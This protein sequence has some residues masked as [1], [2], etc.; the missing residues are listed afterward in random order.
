M[1]TV[2]LN[3]RQRRLVTDL[4]TSGEIHPHYY[5]GNGRWSTRGPDYV[6]Q[7]AS[8][9]SDTGMVSGRH[10]V[11]GNDALYGGHTGAYLRLLPMGRRRKFCRDI[12]DQINTGETSQ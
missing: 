12:K 11:R 7:L 1:K 9:L 5:N 2:K 6:S 3:K 8:I 10:F 4:V